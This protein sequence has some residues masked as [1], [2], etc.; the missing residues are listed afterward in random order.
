VSFPLWGRPGAALALRSHFFEFGEWTGQE[1]GQPAAIRLAH[2]LEMGKRYTVIATTGGGLYRYQLQDLVEV[3]GFENQCP[4]LRFVGRADRGCDL[5]GEKLREPHVQEV[6][7]RVFAAH[8]LAPR[9]ALMV[10][11]AA[12]LRGYCLYLQGDDVERMNTRCQWIAR[13]VERGLCENPYYRY[14]VQLGQLRP[15]VVRIL[16]VRFEEA[17][18]TYEHTCLARGTK[19]GD[20]KSSLLDSWTGWCHQFDALVCDERPSCQV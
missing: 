11:V 19:A 17:W 14:A 12:D 6:L 4:L 8:Q 16:K 1:P 18:Q 9:F 10:P 13:D 5:V 15:L 2:Q 3:T 7:R 20:I